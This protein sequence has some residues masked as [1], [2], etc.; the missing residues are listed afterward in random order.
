MSNSLHAMIQNKPSSI[1]WSQCMLCQEA[2]GE[3]LQ[4]PQSTMRK[5]IDFGAGYRIL[6]TNIA[7]FS[8]LG[9][10]PLSIDVEQLQK[11]GDIVETMVTN[12]G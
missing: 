3:P 10:L 8:E 4:C 6:V 11:C 7:K 1:D 2:T 5:D 12:L 9:C